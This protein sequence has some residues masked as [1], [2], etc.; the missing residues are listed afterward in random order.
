MKKSTSKMLGILSVI[1]WLTMF[2]LI[3]VAF[4]E[5]RN[6]N[7]VS[8]E[9]G[10]GNGFM[11]LIL[12]FLWIVWIVFAGI[13]VFVA[14]GIPHYFF[15]L[16]DKH[17]VSYIYLVKYGSVGPLIILGFTALTLFETIRE[18]PFSQYTTFFIGM[19]AACVAL[20][21]LMVFTHTPIDPKALKNETSITK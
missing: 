19:V 14:I 16:K 11:L 10:Y 13:V 20:I 18:N 17:R 3:M 1:T 4:T 15:Y 5:L 9:P 21:T 12:L 8:D 6:T 2:Y 7:L